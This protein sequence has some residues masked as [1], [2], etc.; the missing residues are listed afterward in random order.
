MDCGSARTHLS[1]ADLDADIV[2]E[3]LSAVLPLDLV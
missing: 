1:L 3:T 2:N